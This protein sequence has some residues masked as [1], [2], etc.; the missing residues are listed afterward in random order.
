MQFLIRKMIEKDLNEAHFIYNYFI[1]NSFSNFEENKI[2]SRKFKS[3]YKKII[4]K[5]LPYL[6]AEHK[7][8][9]V[10]FT[11]LK[12]YRSKS[13]YRYTFENSIYIHPEYTN[14]GIG[15]KL[16]KKLIYSSKKNKNIRNIIAVIGDSGNKSS[17]KIHKKNGFKKI[18]ILKKIG[19]KQDKWIDSVYMQ[20]II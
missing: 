11:Y 18:G 19:F 14:R 13:G 6:V 4:L 15:S 17:I 9:V 20:L 10:G 16:L 7:K 3:D 8:N 12:N 2:S 1:E 5:K